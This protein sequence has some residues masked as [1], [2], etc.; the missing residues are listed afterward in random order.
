[1]TTP[2]AQT[3]NQQVYTRLQ[4]MIRSGSFRLGEQLD[5]R[6]LATD[7]EVS[8]TPIREAISQLV[9]EGIVEYRPY[10]GNFIRKFT[11]KQV[12]DLF[13]VRAALEALAVRLA[14]PKIS[15]EVDIKLR[16]I[17][18]R[19]H[20]ALEVNDITAYSDADR[21]FHETLIHLTGNE[22]LIDSL[23]RLGFKIQMIRTI[24]NRDP[25]VVERTHQ[26]RP[27]I[28][29]ALESRD[30]DLAAKLMEEHIDGVRKAVIAQLQELDQFD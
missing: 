29:A 1:M 26:E 2:P 14:M 7:L 20:Q 16:Q 5:E 23:D 11:V 9:R 3:L 22:T 19:V 25:H 21:E 12:N 13:L 18:D 24:A 15:Q 4:E 28:L 10:R 27:R 6:T 8:R 30:A 17:L